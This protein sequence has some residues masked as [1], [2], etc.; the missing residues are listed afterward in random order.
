MK[1]VTKVERKIEWLVSL[2]P[3]VVLAGLAVAFTRAILPEAAATQ[4]QVFYGGVFFV[5]AFVTLVVLCSNDNVALV[6]LFGGIRMA[7]GR[8]YFKKVFG[9]YPPWSKR[10]WLAMKLIQPIV[11][12]RIAR[13]KSEKNGIKEQLIQ[14]ETPKLE[15]LGILS[16]TPTPEDVRCVLKR[17]RVVLRKQD[18]LRR[19]FER[20][21][22]A[23]NNAVWLASLFSFNV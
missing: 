8:V 17:G 3:L 14:E 18:G 15:E 7:V 13:L 10:D 12:D 4:K 19:Q 6:R 16:V 5:V 11:G 23:V 22:D 20:A 2:A 21:D 9:I 1:V